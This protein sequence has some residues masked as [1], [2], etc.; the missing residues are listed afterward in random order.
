MQLEYQGVDLVPASKSA[1]SAPVLTR[2]GA[3]RELTQAGSGSAS[4]ESASNLCPQTDLTRNYQ[5][6]CMTA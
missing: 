1:Y 3:V 4:N 6:N 5:A 2:Y